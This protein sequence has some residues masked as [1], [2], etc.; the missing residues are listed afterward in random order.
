MVTV[1]YLV[2]NVGLF[3]QKDISRRQRIANELVDA[4]VIFLESQRGPRVVESTLEEEWAV[5]GLVDLVDRHEDDV[6]A[7]AIGCFGDPGLDALREYTDVPVVGPAEA[8]A[9]TAAM[10]GESF[11][12]LNLTDGTEPVMK[13]LFRGYSVEDRLAS[14]RTLDVGV[15][16]IDDQSADLAQQMVSE[17]QAAVEEDGADA[18]IPGCMGL[19]FVGNDNRIS[20]DVDVPFLDPLAISLETARVWASQGITQSPTAS[21]SVDRSRLTG[22][23][24]APHATSNDD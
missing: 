8:A 20:E 5:P 16:D 1:G 18:L 24:E 4:D 23:V 12:L 22:L 2:V 19:A 15:A 13:R 17:G 7:F 9:H 21:P 10:V 14:V 11:S 3:T 6:D